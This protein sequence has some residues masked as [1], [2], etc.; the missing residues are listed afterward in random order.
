MTEKKK[1][2][3]WAMVVVLLIAAILFLLLGG[4]EDA[5]VN[6]DAEVPSVEM[7]LQQEESTPISEEKTEPTP[8]PIPEEVELPFIP[9]D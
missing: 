3:I 5:D 6:A 1:I 9:V 8:E 4:K 2:I 7:Q